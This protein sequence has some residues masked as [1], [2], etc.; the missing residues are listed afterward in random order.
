MD[1]SQEQQKLRERYLLAMIE[2]TCPLQQD[3]GDR[4]VALELLIEAAGMLKDRLQGELEGLRQ[5]EAD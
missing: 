4:E 1:R 5:E 2:A 3:A